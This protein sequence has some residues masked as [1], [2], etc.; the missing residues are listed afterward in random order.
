MNEEI[1]I[2][3]MGLLLTQVRYARHA[4]E[5]IERA[6]TRYAGIALNV[7]GGTGGTPWGA[8]PMIDGA[9]KVYVVNIA[10]LTQ[11]ESVGDVLSG[12]MGGAGR[13]LGGF[14]GGLVG[15]TVS[16]V[17]FPYLF[18]QIGDI[19]RTID[20]ILDKIGRAGPGGES[21]APAGLSLADQLNSVTSVLRE[22]ARLFGAA[23]STPPTPGAAGSGAVDIASYLQPALAVA[24]AATHMING[25]ILVLPLVMGTLASVFSHLDGIQLAI[26]DLLEF[27]FRL[28]LLLRAAILGLVLDTLSLA[29][30]LASTTLGLIA[31]A[32]DTILASVFRV[33]LAGLDTALTALQIA[34]TGIKNVIDALML[35]LRDGLGALLVFIGNLRIFRLVVH[36]A[37]VLP[38]V[39]PALARI[40]DRPL[41]AGETAALSRAAGMAP[42]GLG[43]SGAPVPIAPFPDLAAL[44]LPPSAQADLR[45]SVA[46][47]GTTLR[48]EVGTSLGAVQSTLAGIGTTMR[49]A[50]NG[51]DR[52]LGDEIRLRSR[53][54]GADVSAL[55]GAM[56]EARRVAAERPTTGLEAIANA[57]EGWLRGGGMRTLMEQIT[58]HFRTTPTGGT[59]GAS[60]IPGRTVTA[61][62]ADREDR[63]VVVEIDEVVIELGA[64]PTSGAPATAMAETGF[65]PD[66]Y[67]AWQREID[68]RGGLVAV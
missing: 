51:M 47:L 31:T 14:F 2:N 11:G 37:Q 35:W 39:L 18:A 1:I 52:N 64:V 32:V 16:G 12:V 50:V 19:V 61:V 42:P 13:F 4:L 62:L 8:P 29:G 58:E 25:L 6:T 36:L 15:G 65:D 46:T 45:A 34:S 24:T 56:R 17:A 28:V 55:T 60:S 22:V 53:I 23:T 20:R 44:A 27:A 21:G 26:I 63:R 38:L 67:L 40:V 5:G 30:R 10:D 54:A 41:S 66:A 33:L 57:Y 49:T 59:A 9:L 7:S 3:Q 68:D 48:T 43:G